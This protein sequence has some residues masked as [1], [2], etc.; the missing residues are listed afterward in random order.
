MSIETDLPFAPIC[1]FCADRMERWTH[2]DGKGVVE[3]TFEKSWMCDSSDGV[4]PSGKQCTPH[5]YSGPPDDPDGTKT[6]LQILESIVS[7]ELRHRSSIS[8]AAAA[9]GLALA[10]MS[11]V[12]SALERAFE[13]LYGHPVQR[14]P[15]PVGDPEDMINVIKTALR[16][17]AGVRESATRSG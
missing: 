10:G 12:E 11:E 1:P 16:Y 15:L 17:A 4:S 14:D 3:P 7:S 5:Y 6:K 8:R 2:D 9:R 13:A